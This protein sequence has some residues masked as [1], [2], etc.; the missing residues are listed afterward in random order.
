MWR[1]AMLVTPI[2]LFGDLDIKVCMKQPTDASCV[3]IK[4]V[5]HSLLLKSPYG[6]NQA[7]RI[8]GNEIRKRIMHWKFVQCSVDPRLYYI[9]Y[10]D[11]LIIVCVVVDDI[12]FV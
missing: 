8:W 10:R 5:F 11:G 6:A 7:V 9:S 1:D 2:Y 4:L 12:A 3:V